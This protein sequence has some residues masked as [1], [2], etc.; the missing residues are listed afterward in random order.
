[1]A[2]FVVMEPADGDPEKVRLVR[3]GFSFLAFIVP[4]LWLLWHRLFAEA[5]V[6][7]A[8]MFAIGAGA[9]A[10][11]LGFAGSLASL[12]V[13]IYVG[14]EGAAMRIAGLVR[15]GW[16]EAG[17]IDA[18]TLDDAEARYVAASMDRDAGQYGHDRPSPPS[19][20]LAHRPAGVPPQ[21][22]PALGLFSYPD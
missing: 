6:V 10:A 16:R 13:S 3:D 2:S 18:D 14:L 15:R 11:G 19:A 4:P 1:M 17:V 22:G 7:F 21:S 9:E 20:P 8:L 5:A 12:L